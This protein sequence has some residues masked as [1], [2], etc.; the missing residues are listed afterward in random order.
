MLKKGSVKSKRKIYLLENP[1]SDQAISSL[2]PSGLSTSHSPA[3]KCLSL[4]VK[5]LAHLVSDD[6][7]DLSL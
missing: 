1:F 7:L 4:A 2:M 5:G 6:F 3:N